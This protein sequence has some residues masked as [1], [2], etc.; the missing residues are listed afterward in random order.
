M[1]Q[2]KGFDKELWFP[3]NPLICLDY[4]CRQRFCLTFSLHSNSQIIRSIAWRPFPI[5]VGLASPASAVEAME[6]KLTHAIK[7]TGCKIASHPAC[8][9]PPWLTCFVRTDGTVKLSLATSSFLCSVEEGSVFPFDIRWSDAGSA[10]YCDTEYGQSLEVQ[11]HY[12]CLLWY[13]FTRKI[14]S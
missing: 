13:V 9:F 14:I 8:C 3:R 6:E 7:L 11:W 5:F 4:C 10:N 12:F 2:R 1:V